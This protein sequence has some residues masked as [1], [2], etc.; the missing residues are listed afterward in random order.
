MCCVVSGTGRP[1]PP[2]AETTQQMDEDVRLR[3]KTTMTS[4]DIRRIKANF[5]TNDKCSRRPSFL[6]VC[7]ICGSTSLRCRSCRSKSASRA[8][9]PPFSWTQPKGVSA[10]LPK[11]GKKSVI[12]IRLRSNWVREEMA[13]RQSSRRGY[14][15]QSVRCSFVWRLPGRLKGRTAS[16]YVW[17]RVTRGN[18]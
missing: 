15:L 13:S 16:A 18:L 10:D 4:I 2:S 14:L 5:L 17:S 7:A 1:A 12:I 3:S 11:I 8:P 6:R 9:C